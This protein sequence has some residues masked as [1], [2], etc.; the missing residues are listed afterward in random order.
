MLTTQF[1][2]V[3]GELIVN[4]LEG[5]LG[6]YLTKKFR[7]HRPIPEYDTDRDGDRRAPLRLEEL[8]TQEEL[9]RQGGGARL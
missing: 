1:L 4:R 3:M 2:T 9:A 7:I 6:P 8:V 5:T